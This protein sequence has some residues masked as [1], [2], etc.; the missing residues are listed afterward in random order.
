VYLL[1]GSFVSASHS[2][3]DTFL[4]TQK[5]LKLVDTND[6]EFRAVEEIS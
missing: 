4:F 3:L 2:G 5:G 6:I 1:W